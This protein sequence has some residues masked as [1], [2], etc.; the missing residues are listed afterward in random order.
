[1]APISVTLT[2]RDP[3]TAVVALVGE[4]D[5]YSSQRLENE[6]AVLLEERQRIVVDLRDTEF[7]D[8]TT[9]SA[10]LSA[11]HQAEDGEL[12]FALVLP[13]GDHSQVHQILGITGLDS[14]FAIYDKLEDALAAVHRGLTAKAA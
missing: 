6:L 12:G 8:S 1:M 3:P 11:R 7:I 14:A 4:H 10:L 2:R 9:L 5:P 13:E